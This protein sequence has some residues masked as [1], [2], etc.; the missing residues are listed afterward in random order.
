MTPIPEAR[1]TEPSGS[2]LA[3]GRRLLAVAWEHAGIRLE[4]F[5][6]ELAEK[7]AR[8]I[9]AFVAAAGALPA[10]HWA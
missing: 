3:A 1:V 6:L 2:L 4:L 5:T 10:R 8:F 9:G 7:R